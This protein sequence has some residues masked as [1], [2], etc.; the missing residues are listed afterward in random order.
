MKSGSVVFAFPSHRCSCADTVLSP[1]ASPAADSDEETAAGCCSSPTESRAAA[2]A[3]TGHRTAEGNGS[4]SYTA[5]SSNT[6][7][8]DSSQSFNTKLTILI[9]FSDWHS[10]GDGAGSTA[11]PAAESDLHC[12]HPTPTRNQTAV[13]HLHNPGP[14]THWSTADPGLSPVAAIL[15]KSRVSVVCVLI[16]F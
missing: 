7:E 15:S 2:A 11:S 3:R 5:V 6:S 14:K 10:A 4:S 1:D 12:H 8:L 13:L 16:R 9:V